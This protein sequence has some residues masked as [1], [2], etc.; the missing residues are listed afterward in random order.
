MTQTIQL[1]QIG[2]VPAVPAS[3]V[4]AGDRLMWNFG[5]IYKVLDIIKET[6]KQIVISTT[7]E[8]GGAIYT[9]RLLKTRLVCKL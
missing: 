2:R 6:K 9:Q 5:S 4:K 3:E 7:P 1:Q 8:K